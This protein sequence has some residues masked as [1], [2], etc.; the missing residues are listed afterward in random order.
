MDATK[1]KHGL[2]PRGGRPPVLF[3]RK[4][5]HRLRSN[6]LSWDKIATFLSQGRKKSLSGETLRRQMADYVPPQSDT[7]AMPKAAPQLPSTLE[8]GLAATDRVSA[9]ELTACAPPSPPDPSA[10]KL[11]DDKRREVGKISRGDGVVAAR[12]IEPHPPP[13]MVPVPAT[14]ATQDAPKPPAWNQ[15]LQSARSMRLFYKDDKLFAERCPSEAA[16]LDEY[17]RARA[18]AEVKTNQL[19]DAELASHQNPVHLYCDCEECQRLIAAG[20]RRYSE[21]VGKARWVKMAE[22]K[23]KPVP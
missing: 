8:P 20:Y 23:P 18:A 9:T 22:P 12:P 7:N 14:G 3:D 11:G 15:E 5:V 16:L 4:E 19:S 17:E 6:G 1:P 2:K 10:T 13:P 21:E